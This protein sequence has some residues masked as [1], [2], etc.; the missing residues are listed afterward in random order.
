MGKA[1]L[2]FCRTG[3]K[4]D[5]KSGIL[6]LWDT[7]TAFFERY[8]WLLKQGLAFVIPCRMGI[9]SSMS[10]DDKKKPRFMNLYEVVSANRKKAM[11]LTIKSCPFTEYHVAH[12]LMETLKKRGKHCTIIKMTSC[13]DAQNAP[14]PATI[15]SLFHNGKYVTNDLSVCLDS[16]WDKVMTK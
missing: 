3:S 11:W 9:A 8:K 5:K 7:K 12:E 15:F 4:K 10:F 6:R 1:L 13:E 16:R 14:S 2:E